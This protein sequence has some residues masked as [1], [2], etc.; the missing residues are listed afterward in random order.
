M[1]SAHPPIES[2]LSIAREAGA[3]VK[4]M[5]RQVSL[6]VK[7]DSSVVTE[8]DISA[9]NLIIRSLKRLSPDIP[10][11]SEEN[12]E[13]ENQQTLASAADAWVIDPLDVTA[14]YAAGGNTYSINIAR[15]KNGV[16]VMG[17]L[18]FPGLEELYYTGAN[19][20]AYKQTGK[21]APR[22]I[23][24]APVSAGTKTAAVSP[25]KHASHA[26]VAENTLKVI[27]TRGQ[28]RA[29]L[30]ATGEATFS[31]ERAG[32][33]IWDSAATYAIVVAAG[34]A[35]Q[36]QDG[37]DLL[38]N[39]SLELPAYFVGH[40]DLLGHLHKV[41]PDAALTETPVPAK[42]RKNA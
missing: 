37:G 28:R 31:S 35:I 5:Q 8:A 17:V 10:I 23:H 4:T 19:C 6:S 30:V 24:V 40:P 32:F 25:H 2:I 27:F 41:E 42:K 26:P 12:P 18:C 38:Y 11:I 29:C 14:N 34:G 13:A 9:N 20:K 3:L 22:V 1:P 16:P 36:K 7:Q 21:D 15:V 39:L 33:R